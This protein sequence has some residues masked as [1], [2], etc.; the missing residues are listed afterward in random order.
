MSFPRSRRRTSTSPVEVIGSDAVPSN[1][2]WIR[3]GNVQIADVGEPEMWLGWAALDEVARGMLGLPPVDEQIPLAPVRRRRTS[4][5]SR[6]TRTSCS[7][8]TSRPVQEALGPEIGQRAG[9]WPCE[10]S[11][12]LLELRGLDEE[13]RRR[14]RAVFGR[15]R[16]SARRGSRADRPERL[17]KSTL[18]QDRL[19]LSRARL[20]RNLHAR[21]AVP[22]PIKPGEAAG[23]ACASFIR[24]S[25]SCEHDRPG[26]PPRRPIP[27]TAAS[28]GC[29]GGRS[30]APR[31]GSLADIGLDIDPDMRV[32]D[33]PDGGARAHR[34]RARD[35]GHRSR[36][37]RG[38]HPR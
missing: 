34:L 30:A 26:K 6:T 35:P 15:P 2:D 7:A 25:A 5:T 23:S 9:R 16:R 36:A 17:G 8:A 14:S 27:A 29:A 37:R 11:A 20:R 24:T 28:A 4:R 1:L 10:R 22:L 19:R 33:V 3:H 31:G 18:D 12:A 38:S 32:K 21:R 13:L